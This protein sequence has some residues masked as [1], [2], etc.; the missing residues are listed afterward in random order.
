MSLV[1]FQDARLNGPQHDEEL[2]CEQRDL[3][4]GAH[5]R[6]PIGHGAGHSGQRWQEE[7]LQPERSSGG[8]RGQPSQPQHFT[9]QWARL[10]AME[11][12]VYV[13]GTVKAHTIHYTCNY[14]YVKSCFG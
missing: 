5:R 10:V 1:S 2:Q 4:P 7:T 6:Q 8:H 3:Q 11:T 9:D 13:L 12:R 14:Q